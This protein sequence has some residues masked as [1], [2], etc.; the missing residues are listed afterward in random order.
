M[1]VIEESHMEWKKLISTKGI[2]EE[3]KT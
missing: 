1:R 2:S 3:F